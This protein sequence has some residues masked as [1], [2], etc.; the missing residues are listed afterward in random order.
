MDINKEE[1]LT[2]GYYKQ[3]LGYLELKESDNNFEANDKKEKLSKD[4]E[5]QETQE[6]KEEN[7]VIDS[8]KNGIIYSINDEDSETSS[9]FGKKIMKTVLMNL[10]SYWIELIASIS[11]FVTLYIYEILGIYIIQVINSIIEEKTI[12]MISDFIDLLINELGVK[13]L[14]IINISDHL[15]IG[16]FC[17][18]T[19]SSIF[20]DTKKIKKF[21]II[22]FIE[23]IVYYGI[24]IIILGPIINNDL[25]NCIKNVL[26]DEDVSLPDEI[27]QEI[28]KLINQLIDYIVVI[29]AD[30]L[31]TYNIFLE[32][33]VLG[34]L[35]L[36]IFYTPK[37]FLNNKKL[38][39]FFRL[40]SIIP[41]S[42]IIVSLIL[43][44]LQKINGLE[45]SEYISPILLG[46]K[47]TIYGFFIA[48]IF[49]IKYKSVKYSNI[50]DEEDSIDTKIFTKIGSKI[51]AIFGSIEFFAGFFLPGW[52]SVG[53]G[54][55]YLIILCA[56]IFALYDYKKKHKVTFPC[57]H[58]GDMSKCFKIIVKVVGYSLIIILGLA[59]ISLA[60]KFINDYIIPIFVFIIDNWDNIAN[61]LSVLK[62][63]FNV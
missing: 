4:N 62:K 17:L 18:T 53:I 15:S 34:S 57:C 9:S 6:K 60:I 55:K 49:V 35:Y 3:E 44:A 56:P 33:L 23:V 36:F 2:D 22:I 47:V 52:A 51:F 50:F 11:L 27:K 61:S 8:E 14:L 31:S 1:K 42:Y 16:F 41:I 30:F 46:Q 45:I 59:F 25:R 37:R 24:S 48:T 63:L 5:N 28:I 19:F 54:R 10:N 20:N 40:L 32:K 21:F 7:S 13:W 43:R 26:E 12:E 39:L 29:L 38:L 58:K